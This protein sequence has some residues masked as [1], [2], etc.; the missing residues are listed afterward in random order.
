MFREGGSA[1]GENGSKSN[2]NSLH[3][4]TTY[5]QIFTLAFGSILLCSD[6]ISEGNSKSIYSALEESGSGNKKIGALGD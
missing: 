5:L 2:T 4:S 3:Y 1:L 6:E